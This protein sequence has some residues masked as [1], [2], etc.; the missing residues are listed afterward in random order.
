MCFL[1]MPGL[2]AVILVLMVRHGED[3]AFLVQKLAAAV[4]VLDNLG[5]VCL[6]PFWWD[7]VT[8]LNGVVMHGARK[9]LM[10]A[11][12]GRIRDLP[13]LSF[14]QQEGGSRY[15]CGLSGLFR[16]GTRVGGGAMQRMNSTYA[17][18]S[19]SEVL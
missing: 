2:G 10:D 11:S 8:L 5:P 6:A 19:C 13:R 18:R 16:R 4:P 12:A 7:W 15:A 3:G 17:R 14:H 9:A 1:L